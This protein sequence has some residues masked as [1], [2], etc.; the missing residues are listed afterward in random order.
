[1]SSRVRRAHGSIGMRPPRSRA[2]EQRKRQKCGASEETDQEKPQ[3]GSVRF[4]VTAA[5]ADQRRAA[6]QLRR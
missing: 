1:V 5:Q 4:P 6:P 3:A 2:G